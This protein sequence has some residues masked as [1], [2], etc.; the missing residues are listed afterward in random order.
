MSAAL[1][2][3]GIDVFVEGDGGESIVMI[4]GWPDTWRLWDAQAAFFKDRYRCVRFTLPGFDIDKPRRAFSFAETMS[5]IGNI[6]DRTCPGQRVILMLHDWGCAFGYQYAMRNPSR[7]SRIIGVDIGDTGTRQHAR[8]LSATAKMMAFSYQ[9]WLAIAWRIG[10]PLGDWM[11]RWL[12]RVFRAP[13]DQRLIDSRMDYP[14]YIAWFKAHGSYRDM[15]R[16]EPPVPMLFVYGK[17]KP[18]LFHT[19]AWADALAARPGCAVRAFDTG[20]WVMSEQPR[21]FNE[22][23]DAWLAG[24]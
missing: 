9:M 22:A 2:V 6:V 16:F 11:T 10:G 7:V 21:Q 8:S 20:H 24:R 4:H 5:V 3:D 15:V 12:A 19:P 17:R 18:F 1:E 14:Y 23:V 13:S